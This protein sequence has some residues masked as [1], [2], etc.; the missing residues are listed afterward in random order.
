M[1]LF[2][3]FKKKEVLDEG[4]Q[5]TKQSLLSKITHAIAGRST[6]DDDVLDD[7]EDV[8]ITSD[9]GVDTTL[10]IIKRVQ[11]R[12]KRDN[13]VGTSELN[14]LLKDEIAEMLVQS[15]EGFIRLLPALPDEWKRGKVSGLC[16]RGGFE[17]KEL[18]WEDGAITRCSIISHNGGTLHVMLDGNI[19]DFDTKPGKTVIVR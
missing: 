15:H 10:D 17:I 1:G 4:L 9:V 19:L 8:L 7:L 5:T 18:C 6:I 16:C 2:D 14:A 3:I 12:V 11:E 13:Y